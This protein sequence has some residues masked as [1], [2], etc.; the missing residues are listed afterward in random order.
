MSPPGSREMIMLLIMLPSS[1]ESSLP[2][3][4]LGGLWRED[5]SPMGFWDS[6]PQTPLGAS[7][8]L[9]CA[10]SPFLVSEFSDYPE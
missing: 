3:S 2:S 1:L 5:T 10:G 6:F 7:R 8:V 4:R 9:G